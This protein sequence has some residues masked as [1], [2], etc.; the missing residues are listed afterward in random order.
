MTF[1]VRI[2]SLHESLLVQTAGFLSFKMPPPS[3]LLCAA[4]VDLQDQGAAR[5][6]WSDWDMCEDVSKHS[7]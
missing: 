6:R 3:V 2:A 7:E 5:K 1:F 4:H